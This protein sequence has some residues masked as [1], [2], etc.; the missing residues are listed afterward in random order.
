MPDLSA[1]RNLFDQARLRIR[2][3]QRRLRIGAATERR[4]L[5]ALAVR[6]QHGH[7]LPRAD[8][9]IDFCCDVVVVEADWQRAAE[10]VALKAA[11]GRSGQERLEIS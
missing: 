2:Q 8:L 1:R 10:I 6:E 5:A 4:R 7:L 9:Q 3:R 11:V